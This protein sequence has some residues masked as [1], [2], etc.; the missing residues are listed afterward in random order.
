MKKLFF[1]LAG[2]FLFNQNINSVYACS[3]IYKPPV[4]FDSTE[5]IFTGRIIGF[6]GALIS[7]SLHRSFQG[8][9]IEIVD[10][11]YLP[12]TPSGF[13]EII[14]YE[15][16]PAC[17]LTTWDE[18][19]FKMVYPLEA[20][21]RIVGKETKYLKNNI[22]PGNIRLDINPHDLFDLSENFNEP[23][24]LFSTHSSTYDYRYACRDS[25]ESFQ[26]MLPIYDSKTSENLL[27]SF[28][29]Q[30][31]YELRKD[32]YRLSIAPSDSDKS[33]IIKRLLLFTK[34]SKKDFLSIIN[35]NIQNE[36][37]KKELT[38]LIPKQFE[39]PAID[40]A[41]HP[42]IPA[43]L[44]S[45]WYQTNGPCGGYIT[46]LAIKDK[47]SKLMTIFAGSR[48]NGVFRSTDSGENWIAAN[49]GLTNPYLYTLFAD[50]N[51]IYAGTD[52]G[53]FKSTNNGDKWTAINNGFEIKRVFRVYAF[54]AK[55]DFLFAGT[56]SHGMFR[57]TNN[58]E[59]WI[60]INNGLTNKQVTTIYVTGKHIYAGTYGGIFLST[61]NGDSW[62]AINKGLPE[63]YYPGKKS[64]WLYVNT[65]LM[66]GKKLFIGTEENG[67]YVSTNFGASWDTAG[68][69]SRYNRIY[70]VTGDSSNLFLSTSAGVFHSTDNGISWAVSN[71]KLTQYEHASIVVHGNLIF[72]GTGHGIFCSTNYGKDWFVINNGLK[73]M[74]VNDL[75]YVGDSLFTGTYDNGIFLS[76]DNGLNWKRLK[77]DSLFHEFKTIVSDNKNLLVR[78]G[79][80]IYLSTDI[81]KS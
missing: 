46:C 38:S 57:S 55:G 24:I 17:E 13:F 42:E 62:Q 40:T 22:P 80:G 14:P 76:S 6:T 68:M 65:I 18:N 31:H 78:T 73:N 8:L 77:N 60:E 52:G 2:L 23:V 63:R 39:N 30:F 1:C 51:N 49:N 29:N 11:V 3:M 4:K 56:N 54:A 72:V 15:L 47:H 28:A 36:K 32:L 5:Y 67:I 71:L 79:G 10:P 16:G 9:I 33:V 20:V 35:S 81:G 27:I 59:N 19:S 26:K 12:K 44:S 21:L 41:L 66:R 74:E 48:I 34:Y 25:I 7:D 70:S 75:V 69:N 61:N 58:G 45:R 50:G 53:A 64:L 37:I 43:S